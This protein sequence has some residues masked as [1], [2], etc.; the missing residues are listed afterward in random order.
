MSIIA[1]LENEDEHGSRRNCSNWVFEFFSNLGRML[2]QQVPLLSSD[3][4]QISRFDAL[5]WEQ[6]LAFALCDKS[7]MES[8]LF[9]FDWLL[10]WADVCYFSVLVALAS[11]KGTSFRP[12]CHLIRNTLWSNACLEAWACP[13]HTMKHACSVWV[14]LAQV[15]GRFQLALEQCLWTQFELVSDCQT[16][17]DIVRDLGNS[18]GLWPVQHLTT[19]SSLLVR[20][21]FHTETLWKTG[22]SVQSS[23]S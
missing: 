18:V 8:T 23:K 19:T 1:Q 20:S 16:L 10:L 2:P 6:H 13:D 4:S 9:L 14:S 15:S 22:P 12:I 11:S 3:I 21:S 5:S 7:N 17:S